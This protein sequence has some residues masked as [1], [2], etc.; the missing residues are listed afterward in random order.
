MW[1]Q[2]EIATIANKI[3]IQQEMDQII[4]HQP[5]GSVDIRERLSGMDRC[6]W[7]Y[8]FLSGALAAWWRRKRSV[9]S[10]LPCLLFLQS[11][12]CREEVIHLVSDERQ[13]VFL[14]M[15]SMVFL[16]LWWKE[17]VCQS[18]ESKV[19][20]HKPTHLSLTAFQTHSARLSC[21]CV[22]IELPET[23]GEKFSEIKPSGS[24]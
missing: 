16:P 5:K 4:T 19:T 13:R 15:F 24:N 8:D 1:R 9:W 11:G 17:A 6:R 22:G 23:W 21:W 10:Q 3:M 12:Y 7:F 20:K 18:E 14:F 2:F